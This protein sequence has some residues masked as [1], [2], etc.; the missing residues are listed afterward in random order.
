MGVTFDDCQVHHKDY[1]PLNNNWWNL[2]WA[3]QSDHDHIE[4]Y[5]KETGV[6]DFC[7]ENKRIYRNLVDDVNDRDVIEN[8][9][10]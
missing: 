4:R 2:R 7:R 3:I 10:G 5:E 6:Y 1:N 8:F 9:R